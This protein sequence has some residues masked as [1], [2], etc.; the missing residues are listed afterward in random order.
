V[1]GKILEPRRSGSNAQEGDVISR[2]SRDH[3]K[4]MEEGV[5]VVN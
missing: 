1:S 3:G 2:V 4:P 5:L